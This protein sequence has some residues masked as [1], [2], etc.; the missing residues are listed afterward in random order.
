MV[1]SAKTLNPTATSNGATGKLASSNAP[2]SKEN[3]EIINAFHSI[4]TL[5][6]RSE[7]PKVS[8][9]AKDVTKRLEPLLEKLSKNE[10][11]DSVAQ[12]LS[13]LL[14]SIKNGD[15]RSAQNINLNLT[16][17]HWEE[18][19]SSVVIGLKRFLEIAKN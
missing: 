16:T 17:N 10:V 2:I 18:L 8:K 4:F 3:E 19:S 5:F 9:Y 15:F 7:D 14:N 1:P 13:S 12:Q 11:S 6:N